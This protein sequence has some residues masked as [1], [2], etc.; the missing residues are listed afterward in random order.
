MKEHINKWWS[1]YAVVLCAL[2][3]GVLTAAAEEA[4]GTRKKQH[5]TFMVEKNCVVGLEDET[6][7]RE[8]CMTIDE[9]IFW[10]K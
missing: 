5:A 8:G 10:R 6:L 3:A 1:L 2:V 4:K 9:K 7:G